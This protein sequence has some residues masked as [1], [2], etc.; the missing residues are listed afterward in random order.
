MRR[1]RKFGFA[2]L[3]LVLSGACSTVDR[4][5]ELD[6]PY[7]SDSMFIRYSGTACFG[8][9][10]VVDAL[11]FPDGEVFLKGSRPGIQGS[12]HASASAIS[13][14]HDTSFVDLLFTLDDMGLQRL[15]GNYDTLRVCSEIRT[16]HSTR[17]LE[18]SA[19]Q[20]RS[21]IVYYL[22]C[23]GFAEEEAVRSLFEQVEDSLGVNQFIEAEL[24]DE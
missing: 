5:P 19:P 21:R 3:L 22:G 6:W 14:L 13:S 24:P 2:V 1:S 17:I 23:Q 20:G 10:A 16:D 12:E 15:A 4:T 7:G 18:V 8:T 11:A 9:C